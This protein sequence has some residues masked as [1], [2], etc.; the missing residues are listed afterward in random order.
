MTQPTGDEI[1]RQAQREIDARKLHAAE[2]RGIDERGWRIIFLGLLGGLLV[3]LVAWPGVPLSWK[4]YSVVHGVCAQI[5]NVDV[6]GIQLPLC[7][8]NTGIYASFSST[9]IFL[10]LRGRGRASK[11]PQL[12]ITVLLVLLAAV[13]GVDGLNSMARDMLLPHMYTPMNWLRTL[14]GIGLGT[15]VAV[16]VLM[17]FNLALRRDVQSE[18]R[19]IDG[20]GEFAA[21]IG[22]NLLVAIA[23]YANIAASY[24]I[25]ATLAWG[26]IVGVLFVVMLLLTGLLMGYEGQV[27]R[28]GQLARPATVALLLTLVILGAMGFG[29]FYLESQGLMLS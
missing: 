3:A 10:L 27:M 15:G 17:I 19:I 29:R 24:W 2:Q 5:H 28:V 9:I 26:G 1:V 7:A 21:V 12:P 18:Q 20:W 6:G 8:R 22:C 14:T 25:V 23:I 13:M 11:L 16:I 4:M